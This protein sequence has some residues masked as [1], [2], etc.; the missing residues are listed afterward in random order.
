MWAFTHLAGAKAGASA[1]LVLSDAGVLFAAVPGV[2]IIA[3]SSATGV[4]LWQ[5]VPRNNYFDAPGVP[6]M[7]SLSLIP[8]PQGL[9]CVPTG[10]Q[11]VTPALQMSVGGQQAALATLDPRTGASLWEL[12]SGEGYVSQSASTAPD[13]KV[14]FT[15]WYPGLYRLWAMD[16]TT[17]NPAW[18]ANVGNAATTLSPPALGLDGVVYVGSDVPSLTAFNG[19]NGHILWS[20]GMPSPVIAQ[21]IVG[22]NTVYVG[23]ALA[24]GGSASFFAVDGSN[25]TVL[26][27]AALGAVLSPAAMAPDGTLIVV[28]DGGARLY[29]LGLPA[30][31]PSGT[32]SL[33]ATHSGATHSAT[34][35]MSRSGP[36]TRSSTVS[37][38]L[39]R[40]VVPS[41]TASSSPT[42][43]STQSRTR[44]AKR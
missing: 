2:G 40:R 9:L 30:P 28:G 36:A 44:K 43:A 16:G 14:Y 34:P 37:G 12:L 22:A 17:G 13:G 42:T 25:G 29:A 4:P 15:M 11:G 38:S 23:T 26:W 1:Q 27:S 41:R 3:L 35:S 6:D 19:S 8:G 18:I 33:S 32:R 5:A 31:S 7:G 20:V 10:V 21:P 39:S 24:G